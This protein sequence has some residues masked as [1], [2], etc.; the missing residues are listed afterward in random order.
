MPPWAA[1]QPLAYLDNLEC[2]RRHKIGNRMLEPYVHAAERAYYARIAAQFFFD[3]IMYTCAQMEKYLDVAVWDCWRG[4][5][6]SRVRSR[7]DGHAGRRDRCA[8]RDRSGVS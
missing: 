2:T 6:G 4:T 1:F 8:G 5:Q 7:V 3:L